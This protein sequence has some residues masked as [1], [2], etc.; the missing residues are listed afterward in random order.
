[1]KESSLLRSP[2]Y[3]GMVLHA[4]VWYSEKRV[5]EI[6]VLE[7]G[8]P[9]SDPDVEIMDIFAGFVQIHISI[10]KSRYLSGFDIVDTFSALLENRAVTP[11]ELLNVN[12][13]TD[14]KTDD[15]FAVAVADTSSGNDNPM[16]AVFRDK[17]KTAFP[18]SVTFIFNK[19]VVSIINISRSDGYAAVS[20]QI[21]RLISSESLHCGL[22]FEYTG[23]EQTLQYYNL[24][25]LACTIATKLDRNFLDMYSAAQFRISERIHQISDLQELIHPDL[26][27]LDRLDP[28]RTSHYLETLYAYLLCGGNY[29]DTANYLGLHRNS[30]IYRMNRIQG[31]IKSDL[32][33]V[34]NKHLLLIS[35][36]L[37]GI[38]F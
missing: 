19:H 16:L 26:L 27:R 15:E 25:S 17:L 33:D 12:N 13:Q 21:S 29:T 31:I 22:S 4:N 18:C 9:F 23:I 38:S 28:H 1:M 32:N 6:I 2:A 24:A 14:W 34:H 7:N 20:R 8:R 5:C 30:L 10:N 36:L 35:Y 11:L 3:G 37:M